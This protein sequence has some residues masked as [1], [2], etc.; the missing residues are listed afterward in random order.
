MAGK[1]TVSKINSLKPT[2]GDY[3]KPDG[4]SLY[5]KVNKGSGTKSWQFRYNGSYMGIGSYP[6]LSLQN[7]RKLAV[8]YKE[9]IA[10]GEDPRAYRDS[11]KG[12]DELLFSNVA[13]NYIQ[14]KIETKS[15]TGQ[16]IKKNPGYYEKDIA[17]IFKKRHI[18]KIAIQELLNFFN[19]FKDTPTKQD[20]LFDILSGMFR[21]ATYHCGLEHNIMAGLKRGEILMPEK[22]KRYSHIDPLRQ[23]SWLSTLLNDM[24][25][26]RGQIQTIKALQILPYLGF[27][28]SMIAELKWSEVYLDGT[29]NE[30]R[31]HILIEESSRMKNR[32]EFAQPLAKEAVEILKYMKSINGNKE[33]VFS[34]IKSKPIS[35][36]TIN[37]AFKR[38]GYD[39]T[40]DKPAQTTHG[41]RHIISTLLHSLATEKG[42]SY[43][44]IETLLQHEAQNKV[45]ATYN[46]YDYFKDRCEIIDGLAECMND[47]KLNSNIIKFG[48]NS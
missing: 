22:G 17:P 42:W 37:Q 1:L 36:G 33:H 9:L 27:R 18:N 23:R 35:I 21:Y 11:L 34:S 12:K 7:A 4:N 41:F 16:T 30:A 20:K 28:P 2:D 10:N 13:K 6:A 47:I 14:W 46:T 15:W 5:L 40:G 31:P 29:E 24:D 25:S 44:A 39:G 3:R 8:Q 45:Q 19:K 38:M 32:K 26:Y 48:S 43:I